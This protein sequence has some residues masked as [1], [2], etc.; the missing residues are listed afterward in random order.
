MSVTDIVE[1]VGN[2]AIKMQEILKAGGDDP[3]AAVSIGT[4]HASIKALKDMLPVMRE[5]EGMRVDDLEAEVAT[6]R[7][8]IELIV[9]QFRRENEELRVKV[10]ELEAQIARAE[11]GKK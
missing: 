10:T 3:K 5:A 11:R 4:F 9:K 8:E 2:I 1:M 6:W 7:T